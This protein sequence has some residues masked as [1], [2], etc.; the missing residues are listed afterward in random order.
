MSFAVI[1]LYRMSG[2]KLS[3]ELRAE[4][5]ALHDENDL[6]YGELAA[7]YSLS[8]STVYNIVHKKQVYGTVIDRPRSG[9]P[10]VSS[11]RDDR[12]LLRLSRANRRLSAS[13]LR[14]QWSITAS[15][16]TVKSRLRQGG[17][18]G[19]IAVRKPFW[20]EVHKR[21]RMAWCK[22]RKDWT[23]DQWRTMR[24]TDES[25]FCLI[26]NSHRVY[27]RRGVKEKYRENCVATSQKWRSP[28]LMVW[29]AIGANGVG[30]LHKCTGT[31][32]QQRYLAILEEYRDFFHGGVLVHDNAPCHSAQSVK[33]WLHEED[34][35]NLHVPPLSPD[36]NP[37]EHIWAAMKLRLRGKTFVSKDEL[38]NELQL[39]WNSFSVS[40][41]RTLIDS[42]PQR[43][44]A[45][46]ANRGG[47]THY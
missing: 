14:Q 47:A 4:I 44:R 19:C 42:M 38:W 1:F 6:S 22:A 20:K 21:N 10:K 17:L 15:L 45:V 39:L 36:L 46:L 28:T 26:P 12:R 24:Y 43:V 23:L 25:S 29:G 27:V 5:A 34:V 8:K 32:N 31:V 2:K 33:N 13:E 37:I 35:E 40:F 11:A 7:R 41:V 30:P 3:V 16:S 18:K 9:R